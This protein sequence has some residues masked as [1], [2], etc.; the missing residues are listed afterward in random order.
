M[1]SIDAYEIENQSSGCDDARR[2]GGFLLPK[3]STVSAL[4]SLGAT[5]DLIDCCLKS[6]EHN[7][8]E[9][10]HM[11]THFMKELFQKIP[12]ELPNQPGPEEKRRFLL[13]AIGGGWCVDKLGQKLPPLKKRKLSKKT[14]RGKLNKEKTNEGKSK[15]VQLEF[16]DTL[17]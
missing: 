5:I 14:R 10:C 4:K 1:W 16:S 12:V 7:F 13:H 8:I 3:H 2:G 6:L 9:C 17:E 15:M 11:H